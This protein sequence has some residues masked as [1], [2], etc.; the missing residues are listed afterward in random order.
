MT[1]IYIPEHLY[2]KVD[3]SSLARVRDT[4]KRVL[5]TSQNEAEKNGRGESL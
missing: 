1:K 5:Q 4:L 2:G 3:Y